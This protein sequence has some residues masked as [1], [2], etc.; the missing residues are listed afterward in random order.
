MK[1]IEQVRLGDIS[2]AQ[3]EQL[4]GFLDAERLGLTDRIY[5]LEAARRRRKLA[6]SL[7]MAPA[8]AELDELDVSLD[9]LLDVP[10][11]AWAA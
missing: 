6:A 7:G 1:L 9:E 5:S 8:D 4:M 10:R 11:S 3:Y 2:T